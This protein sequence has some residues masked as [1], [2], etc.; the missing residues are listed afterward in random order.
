MNYLEN[1][2]K[3][4][5]IHPT[6]KRQLVSIIATFQTY[7]LTYKRSFDESGPIMDQ[8]GYALG[9]TRSWMWVAGLFADQRHIAHHGA[10]LDQYCSATLS[11][12]FWIAVALHS[13][14]P[15]VRTTVGD[16][17]RA[18]LWP[19]LTLPLLALKIVSSEK[20]NLFRTS[21][22]ALVKKSVH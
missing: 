3:K 9:L 5:G 15:K 19:K 21:L 8:S 13:V 22:F 18:P 7:I 4:L 12:L 16:F 2:P 11:R 20:K 1:A 10:I 17:W 14:W 6:K